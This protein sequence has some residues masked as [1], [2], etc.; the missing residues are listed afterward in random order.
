[1][2]LVAFAYRDFRRKTSSIFG[3]FVTKAEK[4]VGMVNLF[5]L[6]RDD[7]QWAEI[8]CRYIVSILASGYIRVVMKNSNKSGRGGFHRLEAHV[9]LQN[10]LHK[11]Y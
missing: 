6:A 10:I 3:K 8:S 11:N 9:D 4:H 1:M 7:F 5:V 2:D